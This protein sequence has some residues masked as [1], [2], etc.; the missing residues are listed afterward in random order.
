[1]MLGDWLYVA[2]QDSLENGQ[3]TRCDGHWAA[4][5]EETGFIVVRDQNALTLKSLEPERFHQPGES[6]RRINNPPGDVEGWTSELANAKGDNV[7][8]EHDHLPERGKIWFRTYR[9]VIDASPAYVAFM[10][11]LRVSAEDPE[12]AAVEVWEIDKSGSSRVVRLDD[13]ETLRNAGYRSSVVHIAGVSVHQ[14]GSQKFHFVYVGDTS[15]AIACVVHEPKRINQQPLIT[16]KFPKLPTLDVSTDKVT[17]AWCDPSSC[18]FVTGHRSGLIAVWSYKEIYN[19][20][21]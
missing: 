17:A 1:M 18:T 8:L 14:T 3:L 5:L 12:K 7:E 13:E 20:L 16:M 19:L 10:T 11:N 9:A 6:F 2:R 21:P 4:I 15:L